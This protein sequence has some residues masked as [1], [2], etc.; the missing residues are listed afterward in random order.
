MVCYVMLYGLLTV[1]FVCEVR[2]TAGAEAGAAE[3][4][5][6]VP[7]PPQPLLAALPAGA[8]FDEIG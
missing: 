5:K 7:V 6:G 1:S 3:G 4:R 2:G 8:V